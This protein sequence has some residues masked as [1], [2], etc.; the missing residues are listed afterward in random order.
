LNTKAFPNILGCGQSERRCDDT[1]HVGV[2]IPVSRV[3]LGGVDLPGR[4]VWVQ[5][6]SLVWLV[7]LVELQD[8]CWL[9]WMMI[10]LV[11]SSLPHAKV[12]LVF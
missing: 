11:S 12:N 6:V 2:G 9:G 10:S 4:K 5:L 1:K 3:V 7:Q 8:S